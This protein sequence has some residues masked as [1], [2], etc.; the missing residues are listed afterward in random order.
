MQNSIILPGSLQNA[1]KYLKIFNIF[2]LSSVKEGLPYVILEAMN[3]EVPIIATCVGGI[4][5][6]I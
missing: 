2:I 3:A 5:E 6:M 4:P 1:Q